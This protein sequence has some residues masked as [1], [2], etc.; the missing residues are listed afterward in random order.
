VGVS[1][2]DTCGVRDHARLLAQQLSRE[3]VSCELHWLVRTDAGLGAARSELR[4]WTGGLV[5]EIARHEP[6][7]VLLHYSVFSYSY[8]GFPLFVHRTLSALRSLELPLITVLHEYAYPW[9]RDGV[10]GAAWAVTQ[11]AALIDV[12][13]AS[14]AAVATV[15]FRAE[16]LASRAWLPKRRIVVAP[17]FSNLPSPG[18]GARPQGGAPVIGCFGYSYESRAISL[19]LDAMRLLEDRGVSA[20]LLL[21]GAP[22]RSSAVASTWLDAARARELGRPPS[23]TERLPAQDLSDALAGCDVLLFADPAGPMSRKTTL[24]ASL[25]S[26]SPVVALDGP[27]RWPELT[28]SDAARVVA[29]TAASLADAVA[30]L[31]EDE[32][33]RVALGERGAEFARRTMSVERSAEVVGGLLADVLATPSP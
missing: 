19:V 4:A 1:P 14:T 8:R 24:A 30:G 33:L 9:G 2:S 21:L 32:R 15:S 18:T 7:A 26:G 12:M 28:Q 20:Q 10:R 25:A 23:F 5:A 22:G 11:R 13:R 16:W 31:L 6:D 27:R 17:V 3:G 29:P